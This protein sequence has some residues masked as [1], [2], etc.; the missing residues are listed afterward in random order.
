MNRLSATAGARFW[1]RIAFG[2]LATLVFIVPWQNMIF[3]EG[4]GSIGRFFALAT[5]MICVLAVL[6]KGRLR[7]IRPLHVLIGCFVFWVILSILWSEDVALSVTRSLTMLQGGTIVWMIWEFARSPERQRTLLQAFVLGAYVVVGG[8]AFSF[9][10]GSKVNLA[11]ER[12]AAA[13][14]NPDFAGMVLALGVPIAWYLSLG[15][16][17]RFM[18]W[19]NRLY[20]PAAFIAI[21][22]TGTRTSFVGVL[23]IVPFVLVSL[24]GLSLKE[25]I[26]AAILYPACLAIFLP[27]VP[28]EA[29]ERMAT[30][31]EEIVYGDLGNR[32]YVWRA[33]IEV[34]MDHPVLGV[35]AGGFQEAA[36]PALYAMLS[37]SLTAHNAFLS[38]LAELGPIGFALFL[39]IILI[40]FLMALQG[41]SLDRWF[42]STLLVSWSLMAMLG[43]REYDEATWLLFGLLIAANAHSRLQRRRTQHTRRPSAVSVSSS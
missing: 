20:V 12:Y 2:F 31:D 34:V 35:G 3:F 13:G 14:F 23:A 28:E 27:V 25:R 9:L 36:E 22:L 8:T 38:V 42:W 11:T 40:L 6:V 41:S 15:G 1:R 32:L 18:I 17:Q 10:T 39:S 4:A 24:R 37:V 33:G 5:A 26:L 29:F 21:L 19:L 43:D 30:I 7:A 16:K